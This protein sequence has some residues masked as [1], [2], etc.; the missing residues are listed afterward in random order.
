MIFTFLLDLLYRL[1]NLLVGFLPTGAL[2]SEIGSSIAAL[3][4]YANAF[5]YVI[6]LDTLIQ[7]L[8]LAIAFD[9]ILLLWWFVQWI[10]RKV[11]GMQ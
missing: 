4:G 6:A 5:S 1:L 3:W 9:L 10:I 11:P 7:V 2:P 8:L